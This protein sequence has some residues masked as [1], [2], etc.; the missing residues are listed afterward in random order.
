MGTAH[1]HYITM[2]EKKQV[3]ERNFWFISLCALL[4]ISRYCNN[5]LFLRIALGV[6][7]I[8]VLMSILKGYE[9]WT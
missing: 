3:K 6:N 1:E 4:V 2:K 7:A 9:D 5:D 8:Y